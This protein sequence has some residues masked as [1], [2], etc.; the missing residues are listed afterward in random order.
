ME[1][2]MTSA[3]LFDE[4]VGA[5]LKRIQD[6]LSIME[7]VIF[8]PKSF[9]SRSLDD[10]SLDDEIISMAENDLNEMR[11]LSAEIRNMAGCY[12]L[13]H[14]EKISYKLEALVMRYIETIADIKQRVPAHLRNNPMLS[15]LLKDFEEL[16]IRAAKEANSLRLFILEHDADVSETMGPFSNADDLIAALE[17]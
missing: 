11:S 2:K 13:D 15:K 3:T 14:N 8:A 16:Q 5:L 4:N 1:V 12:V 7:S 10:K 9:H 17:E 6:S